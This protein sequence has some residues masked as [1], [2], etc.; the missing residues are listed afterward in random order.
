MIYYLNLDVFESERGFIDNV[1]GIVGIISDCFRYIR[2]YGYFDMIYSY[3]VVYC[4][5]VVLVENFL[6]IFFVF[7]LY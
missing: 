7:K 6:G 3:G 2:V 5:S 1:I 4:I